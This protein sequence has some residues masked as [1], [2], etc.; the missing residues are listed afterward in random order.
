LGRT[1]KGASPLMLAGGGKPQ[2]RQSGKRAWTKQQV[3]QFFEVLAATC[4]V[5]EAARTAGISLSQ[6]Y[7][8]RAADAAFRAHWNKALTTSY[9]ALELVL[10]ERA[11]TGTEKIITRKDGSEERMREYSDQL[12]LSLLKM[13]RGSVADVE[14]AA[15]VTPE[16]AEEVRER[17]IQKLKRLKARNDEEDS[18]ES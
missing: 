8:K 7:K 17:L 4:N 16:S 10:L 3:E 11:F 13:H 1:R 2:L 14:A 9:R 18:A 6:V 12:G 5:T 15:D